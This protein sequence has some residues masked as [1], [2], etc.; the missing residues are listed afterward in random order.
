MQ[1]KYLAKVSLNF[2]EIALFFQKAEKIVG[3]PHC[4]FLSFEPMTDNK[5]F[6]RDQII[7]DCNEPVRVI[8]KFPRA[9]ILHNLLITRDL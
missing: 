1:E 4:Q 5:R 3:I 7:G 9:S 2:A 8:A 6:I